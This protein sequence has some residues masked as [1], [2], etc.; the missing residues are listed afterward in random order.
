MSNFLLTFLYPH[1]YRIQRNFEF[2]ILRLQLHD[3]SLSRHFCVSRPLASSLG[4]QAGL[5]RRHGK[6]VQP[7][8]SH[9]VSHGVTHGKTSQETTGDDT[10]NLKK[11]K[12]GKKMT[13]VDIKPRPVAPF[14]RDTSKD[15]GTLSMNENSQVSKLKNS[16]QATTHSAATETVN[17]IAPLETIL[18]R[19]PPEIGDKSNTSKSLHVHTPP[20]IHHF[21]TYTLVQQVQAGGFTAEQS[22]TAMKA[23]RSLLAVNL[24]VARAG[25]V[26]KSDVENESYLFRAACSELK[27]EILNSRRKSEETMRRD[28]ISLQ[29]EVEIL[30]QKLTQELLT[31]K[32]GLKGMFDDRKMSVR[33]DQRTMESKIQELNYKIT[34][35]LNSDSKFEV[36]GLRWLLTRRSV[37]GILLMAFMVLASLRYAS[38]KSHE[39][40]M[41]KEKETL[42][43]EEAIEY[44]PA[45]GAV[46]ILAAS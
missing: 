45:Q 22:I 4:A 33:M 17:S 19:Q 30:N 38:Y 34:V 15:H 43:S 37:T 23:V 44:S 41:K 2:K 31:L 26:S 39:N 3:K 21:D 46:E 11:F 10:K 32:D 12:K 20:Y 40:M 29:H 27:T 16:D 7:V 5:G 6:A 28:R 36:E 25:L 24:E 14:S 8:V 9:G 1:F 35:M 13:Q 18:K 42:K